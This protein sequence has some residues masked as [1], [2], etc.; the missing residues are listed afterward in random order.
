VEE[1]LEEVLEQDEDLTAMHLTD[2]KE[3][4]H[5]ELS[6][7]EDLEILLETFAKQVEE[8]VNEAENIQ[9]NVQSTQEIVELI[10]DS[11]RNALLSLDLQVSIWTMGLGVGTLLAGL[12]GMNLKSHMEENDFAFP[13]MSFLSVLFAVS[14]SA[15]A[16][17]KLARIRKIGLSPN[18]R[19]KR[20]PWLPLPL[21]RR[22]S[23]GSWP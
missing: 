11:N 9:S 23:Q 22:S 4:R 16:L 3:N 15:A 8:V 2:K 17:R 10:L 12:F 21:R 20:K 5:R 1:A 18:A 13:I 14:F 19:P 6:D 7:H